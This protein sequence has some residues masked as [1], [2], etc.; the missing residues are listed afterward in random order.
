MRADARFAPVF[1][2]W[3]GMRGSNPYALYELIIIG[4]LLQNATVRRTV[5]M[6]EALLGAFGT[7]V[8]FD[9]RTLFAMWTPEE[10]HR[11]SEQE[12][13]ALKVGY[14]A[15]MIKRLSSAFAAGKV[16]EYK[17]RALDHESIR[18]E[19]L[20]LYGVGPE[21]A[22]ILLGAAFHYHSA[23][24]HI[25]PW[26]QKIYSRLFYDRPMVPASRIRDDLNRRYGEYATLAAGYIFEDVFWRRRHQHIPWLEKEIR[27]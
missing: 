10:L 27:L 8:S 25:A 16:D 20:K 26:D 15:K 5:Q 18:R 6:T 14:R 21:T 1:R 12:L 3:H 11:V 7:Q 22:R 2:R 4:V 17:L 24:G 23:I 13:R 19:L 9:R